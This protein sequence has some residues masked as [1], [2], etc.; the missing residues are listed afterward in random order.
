L[1]CQSTRPQIDPNRTISAGK[2][3]IGAFRTYPENYTPPNT[4]TSEY[5]SI[6]LNKIEDFGVHANQY[7]QLDVEIFKSSLD[8]DLLA[9]LWNK[10]WVN[11]LSQSPLISVRRPL[12]FFSNMSECP[13]TFEFQNRAYAVSQLND[14][15]QKLAKA[16]SAVSS[17]KATAPS[18]KDKESKDKEEK[19]KEDNQLAKSVKDRYVNREQSF[20]FLFSIPIFFQYQN[21][22]RGTTRLDCTSVERCHLLDT[23]QPSIKDRKIIAGDRHGDWLMASPYSQFIMA[24]LVYI[25]LHA[26]IFCVNTHKTHHHLWSKAEPFGFGLLH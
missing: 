17:T 3:D 11:T 6:P 10:Y 24:Y 15:Q 13:L 9:M 7:Y 23:P 22:C 1:K 16:Q 19:K 2:V 21:R 25:N 4:S 20:F 14:L 26:S 12:F 8:N 5:Q 18:S